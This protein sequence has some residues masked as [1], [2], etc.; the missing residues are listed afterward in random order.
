MHELQNDDTVRFEGQGKVHFGLVK[1]VGKKFAIVYDISTYDT[2]KI[3]VS[4]LTYVPPVTLDPQQLKMLCRYEI[5]WSELTNGAPDVVR[6]IF[7]EPFTLTLKDLYAGLQNIRNSGDDNSKLYKDWFEPLYSHYCIYLEDFP[8]EKTP[9]DIEILPGLPDRAKKVSGLLGLIENIFNKSIPLKNA[10]AGLIRDIDRYFDDEKK[11]VCERKYNDHEKEDFLLYYD[12]SGGSG[13]L[14][15]ADD[16]TITLYR[17][18]LNELCEKDNK[19]AL[20]LKGKSCYYGDR[21]FDRDPAEAYKLLKR[22]FDL[23]ADPHY[24]VFLGELCYSGEYSDGIPK[25]EEAFR[26]FSIGAAS[27]ILKAMRCVARLFALGRGVPKNTDIAWRIVEEIY[28]VCER[29]FIM[30]DYNCKFAEVAFYRSKCIQSGNFGYHSAN[31]AYESLLQARLAVKKRLEFGNAGDNELL[32]EIQT[33]I[34]EMFGMGAIEK[35][36]KSASIWINSFLYHHLHK[37]RRMVMRVRRLKSGEIKLTFSI[38]KFPDEREQPPMFI[39]ETHTGFCDMV[40]TISVK[41]S[42][43]DLEDIPDEPIYF[44][45]T[46]GHTYFLGGVKVITIN[47]DY[48]FTVK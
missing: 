13:D 42:N 46:D 31:L 45:S 7:S 2:R 8:E 40:S 47:G 34:N 15:S 27:G 35:N 36:S 26:Y 1:S 23:T 29:R 20:K 21:I 14:N 24:A 30:G 10:A 33:S 18:F 25:Y 5:T 37:Y 38:E 43:S 4:R 22:L 39:T 48:I 17:S 41:V 28:S 11:P 12:S 32:E 9:E 3:A 19:L 44:N 16:A 6:V